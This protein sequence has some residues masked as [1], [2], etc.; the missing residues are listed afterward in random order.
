MSTYD[1]SYE[2]D[3]MEICGWCYHHNTT[4]CTFCDE[5]HVNTE[6]TGIPF[7]V[8]NTDS[9]LIKESF[10]TIYKAYVCEDCLD[11]KVY[12]PYFGKMIEITDKWGYPVRCFD[13]KN[14]TGKG[15]NMINYT[16]TIYKMLQAISKAKNDKEIEKILKEDLH[17]YF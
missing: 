7:V 8:P 17:L 12:E 10:N 9:A 11:E 1:R 6:I 16:G 15:W 5:P 3:G 14:I 4:T 2:V 13:I